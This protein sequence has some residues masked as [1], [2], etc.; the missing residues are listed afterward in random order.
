MG[1]AVR[2]CSAFSSTATES[3]Q[4]ISRRVL[5]TFV[6]PPPK[7]KCSPSSS[8]QLFMTG[9]SSGGTQRRKKQEHGTEP[10]PIV[11]RESERSAQ[12]ELFSVLRLV[13]TGKV[14]VSDKT[15]KAPSATIEAIT[16]VLDNGDYYPLPQNKWHDENAGPMRAFAWP[17][18][19]QAGGLVQ[20]FG[21]KLQLT[22]AG[23]R[24]LPNRR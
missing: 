19:I 5:K 21:S 16:T 14:T 15:R 10:I 6:P 20:V 3:C 22:R 12:R 4:T 8:C 24:H 7:L 2:Q 13:D 17:L 9:P 23:G 18:L 11:V 1:T